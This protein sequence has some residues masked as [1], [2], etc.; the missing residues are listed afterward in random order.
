M[1]ETDMYEYIPFFLMKFVSDQS[2]GT[3]TPLIK[4]LR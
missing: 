2:L 3:P 1:Q 4:K